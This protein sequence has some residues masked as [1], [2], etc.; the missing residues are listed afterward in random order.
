[1]PEGPC[2]NQVWSEILEKDLTPRKA[3]NRVRK[4]C[5]EYY[6]VEPGYEFRGIP[7]ILSRAMLIGIDEEGCRI[8]IPFQKPCYGTSLYGIDTDGREIARIRSDLGRKET[9]EP[10]KRTRTGRKKTKRSAG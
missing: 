2:F 1:M 5:R 8:L 3:D 7:I 10:E 6:L 9:V 4:L